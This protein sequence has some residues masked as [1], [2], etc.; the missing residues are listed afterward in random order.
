MEEGSNKGPD[1]KGAMGV[2]SERTAV[3]RGRLSCLCHRANQQAHFSCSS[4]DGLG[5]AGQLC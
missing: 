5:L 4:V 3:V 1:G 2:K